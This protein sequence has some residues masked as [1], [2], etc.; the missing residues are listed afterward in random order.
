MLWLFN[1]TIEISRSSS[2]SCSEKRKGCSNQRKSQLNDDVCWT[3]F[4][5]DHS[6][7]HLLN[8][9]SYR[10]INQSHAIFPAHKHQHSLFNH[11]CV[12]T[13]QIQIVWQWSLINH[14]YMSNICRICVFPSIDGSAWTVQWFAVWLYHKRLFIHGIIIIYCPI[15]AWTRGLAFK[16]HWYH[17]CHGVEERWNDLVLDS[18]MDCWFLFQFIDS[19]A[20]CVKSHWIA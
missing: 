20:S 2:D 19:I 11:F 13:N 12:D 17:Q 7:H 10:N 8:S 5:Q 18:I 14:I 9:Q 4:N 16:S 15:V 1:C 3:W 6:G